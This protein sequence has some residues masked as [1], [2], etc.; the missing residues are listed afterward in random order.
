M[1]EAFIHSRLQS[2]HA[3]SVVAR[4]RSPQCLEKLP[5]SACS[6]IIH[7]LDMPRE[8][9]DTI[10]YEF[11]CNRNIPV[12]A[13]GVGVHY[14][15]WGPL[16]VPGSTLSYKDWKSSY[17]PESAAEPDEISAQPTA[18]SFGPT[19]TLIAASVA[20]DVAEWLGGRSDVGSLGTRRVLRFADNSIMSFGTA[21]TVNAAAL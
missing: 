2:A 14:G 10:V 13:S 16:I 20:K 15:H 18:W 9:I 5:L 4:I 7:C 3:L 1:A 6:L 8:T 17:V 11:G 21:P 19:N 12:I